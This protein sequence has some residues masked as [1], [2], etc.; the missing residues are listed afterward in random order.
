MAGN[1]EEKATR[2]QMSSATLRSYL[3]AGTK[4][5]WNR[6]IFVQQAP[7]IHYSKHVHVQKKLHDGKKTTS[8]LAE[9]KAN[10]NVH[11]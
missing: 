11:F 3:K 5:E 8:L 10:E 7:N 4:P 9:A 2:K 1:F 6:L